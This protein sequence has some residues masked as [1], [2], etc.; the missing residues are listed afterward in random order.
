VLPLTDEESGE[1]WER[2]SEAVAEADYLVVASRR[3]YG[4]LARW[5][6]R[7][8]ETSRYY[9]L[10]FEGELGLDPVACFGRVPRVGALLA[11]RDDPAAGLDFRL[12]AACAEEAA[13]RIDLGQLDESYV[14]YDHPRTIVFRRTGP[15]LGAVDI[16]ALITAENV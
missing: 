13:L 9:R 14:V 4:A 16:R 3:G 10:L 7:Y 15:P 6:E 11:Y 8:P 2:I 5:P 12:P 1:K